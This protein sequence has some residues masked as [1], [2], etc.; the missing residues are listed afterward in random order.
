MNRRTRIAPELLT[1]NIPDFKEPIRYIFCRFGIWFALNDILKAIK[2]YEDHDFSINKCGLSSG[3]YLKVW[4]AVSKRDCRY[5][6][7]VNENGLKK[8]VGK[9]WNKELS[10]KLEQCLTER[11]SICRKPMNIREFCSQ[12]MKEDISDGEVDFCKSL[13]RAIVS[14]SSINPNSLLLEKENMPSIIAMIWYGCTKD[15]S[16]IL[17]EWFSNYFKCVDTYKA[18]QTENFK[19]MLADFTNFKEEN[20]RKEIAMDRKIEIPKLLILDKVD[21]IEGVVRYIILNNERW[22]VIADVL[23]AVGC[24]TPSTYAINKCED[25][26]D[27]EFIKTSC[28]AYDGDSRERNLVNK[29]GVRKLIKKWGWKDSELSN[30][31]ENW[32]CG[33]SITEGQTSELERLD[34]PQKDPE[35]TSSNKEMKMEMV[36]VS[37]EVAQKLLEN[38]KTNRR[39]SNQIVQTYLRDMESGRWMTSSTPISIGNDG[40]LKD[41]QH[42]LMAIVLSGLTI[43]MWVCYNVP[44]DALFDVGKTRTIQDVLRIGRKVD[45]KFATAKFTRIVRYIIKNT[46]LSS[47]QQQSNVSAGEVEAFILKNKE[48]LAKLTEVIGGECRKFSRLGVQVAIWGAIRSGYNTSELHKFNEIL[49]T[50]FQESEIDNPIIA[51]R[52]YMICN[53]GRSFRSETGE[54]V[55]RTQYAIKEYFEGTKKKKSVD[56]GDLLFPID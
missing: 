49:K 7:F 50:G 54:M 41:G 23:K 11:E 36:L 42:R 6:G 39:I 22:F 1:V 12:I 15:K 19:D 14:L 47:C 48:D 27:N 51:L 30:K 55:R 9:G 53:D 56:L 26:G 20:K 34:L 3:E 8:V 35:A 2:A 46:L 40:Q 31:V 28:S 13:L 25:L 44:N 10:T 32:L 18:N 43:P 52:N 21:D 38:N 16:G 4:C 5:I 45:E 24:W 29:A 37:P 33:N 17:E